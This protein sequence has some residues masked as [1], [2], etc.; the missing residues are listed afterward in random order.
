MPE[1]VHS[2]TEE[3]TTQNNKDM[4]PYTNYEGY[5]FVFTDCKLP[6][7]AIETFSRYLRHLYQSIGLDSS[8]LC[9]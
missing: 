7:V 1:E 3:Y 4:V 9:H 8:T 6:G 2:L 5:G